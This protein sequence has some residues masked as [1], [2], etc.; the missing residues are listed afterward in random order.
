MTGEETAAYIAR[1][2]ESLKL[3]V[4]HCDVVMHMAFPASLTYWQSGLVWGT[5]PWTAHETGDLSQPS[6]PQVLAPGEKRVIAVEV[7][8][9]EA[10][11]PTARYH[12]FAPLYA[13]DLH[14]VIV[15]AAKSA[16]PPRTPRRTRGAVA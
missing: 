16:A 7:A 10:L 1:R 15:T 14:I 4:G 11:S 2:W 8:L 5:K 12:L 13:A 9:P 3:V 6:G